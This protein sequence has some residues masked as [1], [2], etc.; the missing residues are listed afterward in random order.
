LSANTTYLYKI[1]AMQGT[2]PSAYSPID[3]ATTTVFS[4]VNLTG[5]TI[6]LEDIA[7]LRIAVNAMR[8]AAALAPA[9]FTDPTITRNVTVLK[10]LHVV[11]LRQAL[12]EARA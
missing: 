9:S 4:N 11:E 6:R 5:A 3:A 12:D 2:T 1:R 8:V 10:R 7:E